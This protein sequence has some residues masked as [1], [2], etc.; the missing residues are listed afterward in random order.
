[1]LKTAVQSGARDERLAPQERGRMRASDSI[2]RVLT[3]LQIKTARRQHLTA[4]SCT[5][6]EI[7]GVR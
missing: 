6:P 7:N 5:K 2:K 1:M 3:G 4:G